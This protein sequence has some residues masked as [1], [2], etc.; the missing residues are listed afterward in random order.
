MAFSTAAH[1]RADGDNTPQWAVFI[2]G[3][4]DTFDVTEELLD[5]VP[6]TGTTSG[7]DLFVCVE[8][9]LKKF[10]IDWSQLVSVSTDGN[11]ALVGVE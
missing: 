5:M 1:E 4:D 9:S 8:E 10:N 6:M 2:H 11:T 3:V 7:N